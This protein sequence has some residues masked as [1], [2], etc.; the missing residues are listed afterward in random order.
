M[1]VDSTL[2]NRKVIDFDESHNLVAGHDRR[3]AIRLGWAQANGFALEV[4]LECEMRLILGAPRQESLTPH[5]AMG[6]SLG[7]MNEEVICSHVRKV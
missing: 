6:R 2:W 4:W 7:C 1:P 5:F 3:P